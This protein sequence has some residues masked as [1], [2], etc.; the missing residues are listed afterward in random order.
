[1]TSEDRERIGVTDDLVRVGCGI[2]GT[3][4]LVT[5]FAQALE[6]ATVTA[7]ARGV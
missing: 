3:Q 7:A 5:D 4:D 2:E 1:M 6:V